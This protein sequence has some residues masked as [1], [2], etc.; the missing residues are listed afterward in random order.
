MK[1]RYSS[2]FTTSAKRH[3]RNIPTHGYDNIDDEIVWGVIE[4]RISTA[5]WRISTSSC[6]RRATSYGAPT[7]EKNGAEGFLFGEDEYPGGTRGVISLLSLTI[8]SNSSGLLRLRHTENRRS[9]MDFSRFAS[10]I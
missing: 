8:I 6:R 5:C 7:G 10:M 1:E 2:T 9:G 3:L 4:E